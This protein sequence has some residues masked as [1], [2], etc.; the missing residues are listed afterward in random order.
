MGVQREFAAEGV[1]A[2]AHSL[3]TKAGNIFRTDTPA[4]VRDLQMQPVFLLA[5]DD[6][7]FAGI[8]V[9]TDVIQ[10]FL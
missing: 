4:V 3:N 9:F 10:Q 2:L 7:H 5:K 1:D 8:G 6:G